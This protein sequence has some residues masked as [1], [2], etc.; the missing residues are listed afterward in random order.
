[1]KVDV[2][3]AEY[4]VLHAARK[5]IIEHRPILFL[6]THSR[7]AHRFTIALLDE[8]EYR[9]EI[10]DGKCMQ[11]TRKLTVLSK[12]LIAEGLITWIKSVLNKS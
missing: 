10:L 7:K 8:L 11:E 3:R 9:F 1:M 12:G 2:E 5:L 6:D 4:D